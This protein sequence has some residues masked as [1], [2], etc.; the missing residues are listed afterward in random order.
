[1]KVATA[2][3]QLDRFDHIGFM[4]LKG[5]IIQ[6]TLSDAYTVSEIIQDIHRSSG[7]KLTVAEFDTLLAR[8]NIL[9]PL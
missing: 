8:N 9:V 5:Y 7:D 2:G 4:K 6:R 1:V 3:L